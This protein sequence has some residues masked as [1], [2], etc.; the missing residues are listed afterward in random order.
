[1]TRTSDHILSEWLVLQVQGGSGKAREALCGLWYPLLYRY[2]VRQLEDGAEAADA[3]QETL[4]KSLDRIALLRDPAA[5]P[6]WIYTILH[7]R[8]LDEVRRRVRQ[9][10]FV[11]QSEEEL[12]TAAVNGYRPDLDLHTDLARAMRKLGS[13]SYQV[14]HL[15]YLHDLGLKDIADITGVPLGTIK[16]RLHTARNQL[17]H[18]LGAYDE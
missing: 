16:S 6:K 7:R 10:R 13:E 11:R 3:V 8:C 15:H 14:V 18:Y 9:R 4:L 2:A 1:M 12:E 17:K 5:Y